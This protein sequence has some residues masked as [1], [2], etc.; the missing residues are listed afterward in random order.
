MASFLAELAIFGCSMATVGISMRL[1][2]NSEP[3]V[4]VTEVFSSFNSVKIEVSA[5]DLQ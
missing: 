2:V 4:D 1:D 3:T 5:H